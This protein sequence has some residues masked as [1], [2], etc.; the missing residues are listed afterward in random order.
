MIPKVE[1]DRPM[2]AR[3]VTIAVVSAIAI[4]FAGTN[5]VHAQRASGRGGRADGAAGRVAVRTNRQA[6]ANMRQLMRGVLFPN[7]NVV[8]AAQNDTFAKTPQA[9]DPSAATDPIT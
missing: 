8:F 3:Y 7:S 9:Q 2:R 4:S 1:A 5:V 6:A